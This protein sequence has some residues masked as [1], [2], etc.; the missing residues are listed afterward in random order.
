MEL[1]RVKQY[2]RIDEEDDDEILLLMMKAAEQYIKDAVG[3]FD[4]TNFKARLLY[5][6]LLQDFYENRI[7]EVKESNKQRLSHVAGSILLQ[8]QAEQLLKGGENS[9]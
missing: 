8:L 4:E 7:L 1:K 9:G 5:L 2:L 6:M 3:E